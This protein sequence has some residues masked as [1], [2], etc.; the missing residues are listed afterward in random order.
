[1]ANSSVGCTSTL[2]EKFVQV[3]RECEMV[4][5][6]VYLTVNNTVISKHAHLRSH[7]FCNVLPCGTPESTPA[8]C[9][10]GPL[11]TC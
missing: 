3:R 7:S 8:D 10:V 4:S 9:G 5:G 11:T 6:S 2:C 1:M